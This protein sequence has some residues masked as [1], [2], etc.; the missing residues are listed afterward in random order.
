[1]LFGVG[2][3]ASGLASTSVGSMAG[4]EIMRGLLKIRIPLFVRRVVTLVP[5]LVLLA[6]LPMTV[7]VG[8]SLLVIAMKSFA[9]LGGYLTSVSLD[10]PLVAVVTAAAIAGSFVG[11]R[12]ISVVPEKA[13]RKGFGY[14]VLLMGA[15][16]LSQELP[17]PAGPI[18]LGV[19][20]LL[21]LAAVVCLM[22]VARCPL[23]SSPAHAM[24]AEDA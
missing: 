24:A 6:G 15:F 17:S 9:G 12:L 2:L 10:W 8:T 5:A 18:I 23:R 19:T 3:L 7:A 11:V 20:A 21:A 13:L 16:V 22:A 14:F 1:M 4:A